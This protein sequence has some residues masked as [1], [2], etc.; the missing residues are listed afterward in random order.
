MPV[1]AEDGSWNFFFVIRFAEGVARE[2][3]AAVVDNL[4]CVLRCLIC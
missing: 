1:E 2:F 4:Y 3:I